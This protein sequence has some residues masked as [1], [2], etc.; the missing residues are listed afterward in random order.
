M[1]G[2][3]H[4]TEP[5]IASHFQVDLPRNA[6]RLERF[7]SLGRLFRLSARYRSVTLKRRPST[8]DISNEAWCSP[9]DR[10]DIVLLDND[11]LKTRHVHI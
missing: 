8:I 2:R 11:M 7:H 6:V 9:I 10:H 5:E 4:S 3:R 1:P